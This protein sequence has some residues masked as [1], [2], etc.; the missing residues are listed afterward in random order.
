VATREAAAPSKVEEQVGHI[1]SQYQRQG[2][3]PRLAHRRC[4][5]TCG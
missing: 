3:S 5:S 1:R 2:W 4:T